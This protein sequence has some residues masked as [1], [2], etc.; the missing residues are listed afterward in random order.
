MTRRLGLAL[1]LTTFA[2][3]LAGVATAAPAFARSP[4]WQL[5]DAQPFTTDS[6]GFEIAV[7]IPV[8]ASY[9]K[10]LKA[11]DGSTILLE[12]G[13]LRV[14]YTNVQTGQAITENESGPGKLTELADGSVTLTDEGH[15][16]IFLA[17]ADAQRF[18]LPALSVTAGRLQESVSADGTITSL[19]LNGTVLVNICAALS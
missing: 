16:G 14:S 7:T 2:G 19:T 1:V 17:P 3:M 8:N 5:L 18:G 12:T 9:T 11:T 10:I 4:Q 6:C 13:S 15:N